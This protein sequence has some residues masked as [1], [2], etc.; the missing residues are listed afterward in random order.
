MS[1]S[2]TKYIFGG[3]NKRRSNEKDL[4]NVRKFAE[5]LKNKEE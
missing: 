4:E 5:D 3:L 2:F 1:Y